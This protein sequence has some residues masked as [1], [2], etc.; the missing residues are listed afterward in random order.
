MET[1]LAQKVGHGNMDDLWETFWAIHSLVNQQG[2]IINVHKVKAHTLD[3][4]IKWD[5]EPNMVM[6]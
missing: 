1:V 2:W 4:P 3:A 6:M 5:P